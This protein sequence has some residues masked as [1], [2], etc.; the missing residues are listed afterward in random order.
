MAPISLPGFLGSKSETSKIELILVDSLASPLAL[1][2]RRMEN[3]VVSVAK[4][5]TRAIVQLLL[6]NVDNEVPR[7]HES[8]IK[9]LV[10]IAKRNEGRE[11]IIDSLNHPEPAIRKGAKII[12]PEVWG[13][14]AIP[15]A[16]LYEQVYTLM[17]AARDKD[18]PLDD[19]E[20]LMG[21]SQQVLL[22]GE[23][24]KAINDIGK[25]LEFA[26][27]RYKNSESL[28]EYI[29]DMLKIAPEL[30]R[31]GVSIINFDESLKTAIKASRTRTYDFTQ[32]IIDQRVMEMEV[33]DQLR[34]LGQLVK[35]SIKTRPVYDMEVFIPV[36]RRMI[37]KM[38]AVLD[39]IN[40][41]NLSG[42]LPKSIEDMH[43]F[44]LKDFEW[45]YNDDVMRRLG[46]GDSSAHMTIYLIGIAFLKVASVMTPSVAEDIYQKYY[47]GLEEAT[48]I[49]T[50]FWPEV[51]LEFIRGMKP[52]A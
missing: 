45:Y 46:E 4:K 39:G 36:D 19:I 30:H 38:T 42:N 44:L 6:R 34:N 8:I 5:E 12:I 10:E 52:D 51:V 3:R 48:S 47:R 21:I 14:Q 11:S 1:E 41:K 18:I 24:M 13:V 49:Y 43:N 28:K 20:V 31:M 40:T 15:Y 26:R 16:T 32:E 50:V 23:V 35:E 22:D 27:R 29:S 2:R 25:C 7:V 37:T 33:K 17:D 9:C